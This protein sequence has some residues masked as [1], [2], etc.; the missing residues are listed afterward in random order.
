M[1]RHLDDRKRDRILASA[2]EVFGAKGFA[3][4]TVKDV[5]DRAGIAPGTVYTYF[6]DK[7]ELFSSVAQNNWDAFHEQMAL[8]LEGPGSTQEKALALLEDGM[9]R[10]KFLH[11]LMRGM[12]SE[13]LRHNVLSENVNRVTGLL[14]DHLMPDLPESGPWSEFSRDELLAGLHILIVGVLFDAAMT[15]PDELDAKINGM[16]STLANVV[17]RNG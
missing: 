17:R 4:A 11:P 12:Y 2:L 16:K 9:D 1:P 10:I 15:Q 8:I 5:A 13:S 14:A 6:S 3:A 7:V